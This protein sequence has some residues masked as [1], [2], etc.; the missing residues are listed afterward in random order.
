MLKAYKYRLI[1]TAEQAA[2]LGRLFGACRF[3]YNLALE[4]KKMAWESRV[5]LSAYDLMK[6][7]TQLKRHEC[8][9]LSDFYSTTLESE[10][11]HM[12]N[13]YKKFFSGGGFPKFKKRFSKH[14]AEF[15]QGVKV[16][17][18][19]AYLPK[20]GWVEFVQHRLLPVGEIR[21][22]TVSKEPTGKFFISILIQHNLELPP[23]IPVGDVAAIGIDLGLKT[24]AT[25]SDGS[26]LDNPKYLSE[27]L[28]RLRVEQR[29]LSRRFKKGAKEQSKSWQKQKLVVAKLHEKINNRR[30]DFLH[31]ASTSI[32]RQF[33]TIC[34]E[35]LNIKGMLQNGNLSKAI[36]DVGW[37]EFLRML[38]YK[39]EWNG[40]NLIRID[41]FAASSKLCSNCGHVFKELTLSI[42]EWICEN[43]GAF[44]DRDLN[45]AINIKKL[46]L[47]AK[48]STANVTQ[49]S[50]RIGCEKVPQLKQQV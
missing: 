37:S 27:M 32:I 19:R 13:A 18:N 3:V 50:K 6:Q 14:S 33:D 21:T 43:C 9:W 39:A 25:M 47:E 22:C 35:N 41:R 20:T 40:K 42:R 8:N 38:E 28:R 45:A 24:F 16:E 12:D 1:P 46:G 5:N 36:S 26:S 2:Y 48:P 15:R 34:I 31:K 4:T 44:H 29:K 49:K 30:T 17:G 11:S 10:I 23:K 7:L